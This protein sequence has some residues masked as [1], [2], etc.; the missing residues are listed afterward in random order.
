MA[1]GGRADATVIIEA[2]LNDKASKSLA[3]LSQKTVALG[4]KL[5]TLGS[6]VRSTGQSMTIGLTVPIVAI[7]TAITKTFV[8]FDDTMAQISALSNA[9][10]DDVVRWREEILQLAPEVAK[11]PKELAEALFFLASAGL[12]VG[13]EIGILDIA[14]R[15]SAAGLGETKVIAQALSNVIAAYGQSNIDAERTVGI[16][17]AGVREGNL[18]TDEMTAVLGRVLPL[19]SELD[20]TF[21]E[22]T[23]TLA[24][25]SL[26]NADA[27]E[28]ASAFLGIMRA[29]ILAS[30]QG[31]KVLK[32]VGTSYAKIR[33]EIRERGLISTLI[34]L[35][36]RFGDNVEAMAKVFP[37][38]RGLTGLLNLTGEQ[39]GKVEQ[40]FKA[41]A[42]ATED[43]LAKAFKEVQTPGFELRQMV[44]EVQVA[45]IRLGDTVV[46]ILV[47]IMRV[48]TGVMEKLVDAWVRLPGP[49]QQAIVVFA[50]LLAAL[51]PL[52]IIVG[53]LI[54]T[55]GAL[56]VIFGL[57]LG[58]SILLTG[59]L[60]LI[61]IAIAAI[62][63]AIILAIQHWDSITAAMG[64]VVSAVSAL[65]D[66]FET[67]PVIGPIIAKV[68]DLIAFYIKSMVD[69]FEHLIEAGK[70]VISFFGNVFT[71]NWKEAWIDL[72]NIAI[73][74]VN[75]LISE[76]NRLSSAFTDIGNFLLTP[77]GV[78]LPSFNI[79]LLDTI[80][81]PFDAAAKSAEDWRLELELIN[82]A[83]SDEF[84]EAAAK[85]GGAFEDFGDIATGT[86]KKVKEEIALTAQA[87]AEGL[88]RAAAT[89]AT[90]F[91]IS[92]DTVTDLLT[93]MAIK[94]GFVSETVGFAFRKMVDELGLSATQ[95]RELWDDLVTAA[96]EAAILTAEQVVD[97]LS[98]AARTLSEE[99]GL[100]LS[101]IQ[102]S[103]R[104]L[105]IEA[106]FV[107][108][109][110]SGAFLEIIQ[111]L[112]L[113]FDQVLAFIRSL[114]TAADE[115]L[116]FFD[117]VM[118]AVGLIL[119]REQQAIIDAVAVLV[120]E[121]MSM[122]EALLQVLRE[123][124]ETQL[125]ADITAALESLFGEGVTIPDLVGFTIDELQ[126]LLDELL[127]VT[128][129]A[130]NAT[131]V[132]LQLTP[133]G[134]GSLAP[135]TINMG[136][137][138]IIGGDGVERDAREL[139][140]AIEREM[141]S[142]RWRGF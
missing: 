130:A 18:E 44:V 40:I 85:G 49:V 128:L 66:W 17:I 8:G 123:L 94:A 79:P 88:S 52:L 51:G 50:L 127:G 133:A 54:A 83:L 113:G 101:G 76:F 70:S 118:A 59:G 96:R 107:G 81:K 138:T 69:R 125:I 139:T 105:A 89:V 10:I 122:F 5:M 2:M 104:D 46:P 30:P 23:A 39:A 47:S 37:R 28:N 53:A 61:P 95:A 60:I 92:T 13:T 15:A 111:T 78:S 71:G 36:N 27:S 56:M 106:G 63:A 142:R 24:S 100:S 87:M 80:A 103:L 140:D 43:D 35:R 84:P 112:G 7:G 131:S 119:E 108:R 115:T 1:I 116:S 38:I 12:K 45:L 98:D 67:L 99:F 126:A 90:A 58:A 14:A 55:V 82:K 68:R 73:N 20:I 33:E 86:L 93:K 132:P 117:E 121:G 32:A 72:Q 120:A 34:D 42:S 16:L 77:F 26:I 62:I 134:I 25:M 6:R 64:R 135:L 109:D 74:G 3:G 9:A 129:G 75:F 97:S 4:G 114:Q 141:R 19:A 110:I 11:S 137:V 22:L 57:G 136:G 21:A 91:E 31:E 41:V 65:L 124:A 29:L 48:L 102:D